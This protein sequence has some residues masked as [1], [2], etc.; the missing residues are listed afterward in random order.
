LGTTSALDDLAK[1]LITG[2]TEVSEALM[3]IGIAT[4]YLNRWMGRSR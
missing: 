1:L 3:H 4:L 2:S